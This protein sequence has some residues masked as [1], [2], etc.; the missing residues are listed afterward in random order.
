MSATDPRRGLTIE[1]V[2]AVRHELLR[3][4][5]AE[6]QL[7]ATEAAKVRT[8]NPALLRSRATAQPRPPC[9]QTPIASLHECLRTST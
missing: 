9:G 6:D 5:Y 2:T 3:L 7:A 1:V 8:G 4:A